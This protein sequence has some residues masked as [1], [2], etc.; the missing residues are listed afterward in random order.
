MTTDILQ[1]HRVADGTLRFCRHA[2]RTTGTP[3]R[4]SLFL[5][6]G[7][8]PF[9]LLLWLSGLTCTEENFTTKAGAYA[10]AQRLGL[11]VLAPDTSPRGEGVADDAAYDLGQ[12]ASFYVDAT[13]PPWSTHFRMES[14]VTG[15]LRETVAAG[16]PVDIDRCGISGHSMGGHGALT[17]ALHHPGLFRSVSAFAPI[18]SPTRCPWGEKALGAYLGADRA[19]WQTHDA[20][21]L[22]ES[23]AARGH[24]DE[25]LVDQGEA[26]SFLATQLKPELL[27]AAC[28]AAGQP[29]RLRRQAGYDHSYY[30]VSTFIA[31][32]LAWHARRLA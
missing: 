17:L 32:H 7:S 2:S 18:S 13:Q 30:F 3:M 27:E 22:I 28:A 31:D 6:S 21:L 20:A 8:G 23:G 15:E 11:A 1:Q 16:F 4:F 24:Y 25:I 14:Y 19:A 29:L 9:P 5:P 10:A 26:D 12:G